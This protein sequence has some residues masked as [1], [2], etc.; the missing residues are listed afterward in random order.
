MNEIKEVAVRC[1]PA[2]FVAL[3]A[4]AHAKVQPSVHFYSMQ[5][6]PSAFLA[7]FTWMTQ[8]LLKNRRAHSLQDFITSP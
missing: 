6:R 4:P 2:A 5:V 1:R 7:A 3:V 8:K